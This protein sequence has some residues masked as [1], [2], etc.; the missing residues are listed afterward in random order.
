MR[1]TGK[2]HTWNDARGFGFIRP[3]DGGQDIFVHISELPGI[4]PRPED[5]LTFQVSAGR[6][7][8]KKAVDVRLQQVEAAALASDRE[9]EGGSVQRR[10]RE[11]RR[12]AAVGS[13]IGSS[14]LVFAFVCG[15]GWYFYQ[16]HLQAET[17]AA[18]TRG[19]LPIPALCDGRTMCSQMTSCG[20]AKYFL[21]N[22]PRTQMD[23]DGDGVPCEQQWCKSW[24]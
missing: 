11:P 23:G 22:C 18:R 4:R 12:E 21:K 20:E 7:S 13:W 10:R 2:L 17:L 19:E 24:F 14:L 16:R 5:V 3:L 15:A 6:D 1:F 8:K 9:R